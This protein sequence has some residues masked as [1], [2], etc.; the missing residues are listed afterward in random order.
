M[1]PNESQRSLDDWRADLEHEEES[2]RFNA[3]VELASQKD[4]AA[5]PE[6][7]RALSHEVWAIRHYHA[8]RALVHLGESAAPSLISVLDEESIALPVAAHTL[9]KIDPESNRE[10][11]LAVLRR[12]LSSDTAE[13]REDATYVLGEMGEAARPLAS[14]LAA[15]LQDEQATATARRQAAHAL[16]RMGAATRQIAPALV[17][18]LRSDSW[19]A[20]FRAAVVLE[21]MGDEAS[22]VVPDLIALLRS[23]DETTDTRVEAA[24]VLGVIGGASPETVPTLVSALRDSDWWVRLYAARSLGILGAKSAFTGLIGALRDENVD[25]RRSAAY[26]LS[27]L[28]EAA[29]EAVPALVATLEDPVVGGVTA[30]A[31][32][33]VGAAALPALQQALSSESETVSG[34]AA[35]ALKKM[36]APEAGRLLDAW[37]GETGRQPLGFSYADFFLPEPEIVLTPEKESEFERLLQATLTR[38]AGSVV[39]YGCDYPKYE[40]LY[41]LVQRRGCVLHGSNRADLDVMRPIRKSLEAEEGNPLGNINGVYA[42]PDEIW[43]MFFALVD[44]IHHEVWLI[45]GPFE[46]PDAAGEMHKF[47]QFSIN[48]ESLRERP[49]A[50]GM[51]YILPG[52]TFENAGGA[53][54]ASRVPVQPLAK[55]PVSPADFPHLAQMRGFNTRAPGWPDAEGFAFL[56]EVEKIIVRS[57][58]Q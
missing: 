22:G 51:V 7:V 26:A 4:P 37:T 33:K 16:S 19:P 23:A 47:Y 30:E 50:D 54:R 17:S 41:Y 55:L 40:F 31:L 58:P 46:G 13:V 39:D 43:P 57:L 48:V 49:Y 34:R 5:I 11:A 9:Y 56:S 3:A 1:E 10:I 27:R 42:T 29:A 8:H 2:L 52:A 15:V 14:A 53:E 36:A 12:A 38:G 6:L 24:Q 28:E 21:M 18:L 35:Y 25:V 44:R 32:A 20:R 45:N